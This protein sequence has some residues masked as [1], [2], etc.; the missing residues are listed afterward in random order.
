MT[1]I[2]ATRCKNGVILAA[3]RKI[4]MGDE[5]RYEC[6]IAPLFPSK[7]SPLFATTGLTGIRDDFHRIF[8]REAGRVRPHNLYRVRILAEDLLQ[9]FAE[10]YR[11]RLPKGYERI[12]GILVGLRE[13]DSGKAMI[14]HLVGGYGEETSHEVIGRGREFAAPLCKHFLSVDQTL[15]RG[16]EIVVSVISW[17]SKVADS[18]GYEHGGAPDIVVL[19]DNN[20]KFMFLKK[21]KIK[22]V[23]GKLSDM[24]IAKLS[25]FLPKG[26]V[27]EKRTSPSLRKSSY[28][29]IVENPPFYFCS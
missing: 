23:E 5:F 13:L 17:V 3:D 9:R 7:E 29:N 12:S 24:D 19:K 18:V 25:E 1:L 28:Q 22:E 11:D 15:N 8:L 16:M 26:V 20:P 14:Y 21:E 2:I 4:V 27:N 10:R 6:K